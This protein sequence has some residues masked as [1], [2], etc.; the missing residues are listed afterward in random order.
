MEDKF[1]QELQAGEEPMMT[2][3]ELEALQ[4]KLNDDANV[5]YE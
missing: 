3:E 1:T 5:Y 2:E 4:T